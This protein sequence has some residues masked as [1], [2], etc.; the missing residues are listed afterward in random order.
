MKLTS[1]DGTTFGGSGDQYALYLDRNGRT[2]F[3][4][5]PVLR[6]RSNQAGVRDAMNVSPRQIP[7]YVTQNPEYSGTRATDAETRQDLFNLFAPGWGE[8]TL[9]GRLDEFNLSSTSVFL[10]VDV[11]ALQAMVIANDNILAGV[12][13]AVDPIWRAVA[14]TT[15][16]TSGGAYFT[17]PTLAITGGDD[18]TRIRYSIPDPTGRGLAGHP[19]K[20]PIALEVDDFVVCRG[21]VLPHKAQGW[22]RLDIPAGQACIVDVWQD[23]SMTNPQ[24]DTLVMDGLNPTDSDNETWVC[25]D[26]AVLGHPRADGS[27]IGAKLGQTFDDISFGFTTLSSGD[28]PI[29]ILGKTDK[30]DRVYDTVALASGVGMDSIDFTASL[31]GGTGENAFADGRAFVKKLMPGS[32]DWESVYELETE[33]DL[34]TPQSLDGAIGVA[35]GLEPTQ[36]SE[37]VDRT[38]PDNPIFTGYA[39]AHATL[40]VSGTATITL[41]DV[42]TVSEVSTSAAKCAHDQTIENEDTGDIIR[43]VSCLLPAG[44]VRIDCYNKTVEL[45]GDGVGLLDLRFANPFEWLRLMPGTNAYS[46][47]QFTTTITSYDRYVMA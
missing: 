39:A 29:Q 38:D 21:R 13:S 10:R 35:I 16:T 11:V 8:R 32:L 45:L 31:F 20:L 19:V 25:D 3:E 24:A 15:G 22:V 40:D 47:G 6:G 2:G 18:C 5:E 41:A 30:F 1:F 43:F 36:S 12:F 27:F 28:V 34:T 44:G 23:T 26:W 7:F 42:V 14:T 4:I 17:L 37:V 9:V 33:D 46:D